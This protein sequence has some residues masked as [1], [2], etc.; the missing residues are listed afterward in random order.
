MTR[1]TRPHQPQAREHRSRLV[2]DLPQANNLPGGRGEWVDTPVEMTKAGWGYYMDWF[3]RP[4]YADL[5][6][7]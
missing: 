4:E 5:L 2:L 3:Y 6:P 7:K 1:Q